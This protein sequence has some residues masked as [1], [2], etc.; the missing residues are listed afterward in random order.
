MGR[1]AQRLSPI[2]AHGL[3]LIDIGGDGPLAVV[4]EV[5]ADLAYACTWFRHSHGYAMGI[6]DGWRAPHRY[7]HRVIGARMGFPPELSVDHRDR[8]K[9]NNRRSNLRPATPAQQQANRLRRRGREALPIGVWRAAMRSERY[10]AVITVDGQR[11]YLGL[12]DSPEE[13]ARAYDAA[14]LELRGEFA[15]LNYPERSP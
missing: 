5:D 6:T 10:Q 2:W 12:F 15:V 14:A 1:K 11:R 4:D 7:M 8:D 9:L 13:A 3:V